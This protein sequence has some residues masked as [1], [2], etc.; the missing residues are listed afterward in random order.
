MLGNVV[1]LYLQAIDL[2]KKKEVHSNS[3]LSWICEICENNCKCKFS[4]LCGSRE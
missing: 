3:D 1:A 2:K 4:Q